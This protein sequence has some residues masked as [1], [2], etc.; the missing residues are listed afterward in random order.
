[1]TMPRST[2]L[3]VFC[4]LIILWP[5]LAPAMTQEGY[6]GLFDEGRAAFE[7]GRIGEAYDTFNRL[8]I[9]NPQ[10]PAVN[11]M[12]GRSAFEQGMYEEAVMVYDRM[13][14]DAPDNHRV[15]L[16]LGR[17]LMRLGD[18]ENAK[19]HF[20]EVMESSPP[21][22]VRENIKRYVEAANRLLQSHFISG[23]LR[24][25]VGWDDNPKV[26]PD[27]RV[28]DIPVLPGFPFT[29][30][31]KDDDWF[32]GSFLQLG[33]RYKTDAGRLFWDTS[34][35]NYNVWYDTQS[36]ESINFV[37]IQ[38]GPGYTLNTVTLTSALGANHLE[39]H[40]EEYLD[41][42]HL[43]ISIN[44]PLYPQLGYTVTTR[45]E[46]RD[47]EDDSRDSWDAFLAVQPVYSMKRLSC[48]VGL[49]Y[50]YEDADNDEYDLH[51]VEAIPGVA[52]TFPAVVTM[53]LSG[54]YSYSHY[55]EVYTLFEE[56]RKDHLMSISTGL[57]K[58]L[59]ISKN[60]K[61]LFSTGLEHT[62]AKTHSS[63]DLYDYEQNR[64]TFSGTL[65]F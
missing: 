42:A 56:K 62:W 43:S 23:I 15:R 48:F 57:S 10:D 38:T 21:E 35:M 36:S 30:E 24:G 39:R 11:F 19:V 46:L 65:M 2:C 6:Q 8:F 64:I 13:L 25:F 20:L 61:R 7:E 54:R 27:D 3:V 32:G 37:S 12:L 18:Y 26:L 58:D 51:R 59:W 49:R 5:P 34:L 55:K 60:K 40:Y 45:I 50:E 9:Q 33:H 53:R 52:W 4:L 44:H 16:E 17:T 1:M 47:F 63:I 22:A 41:S 29:L 31:K 14:M 28:I